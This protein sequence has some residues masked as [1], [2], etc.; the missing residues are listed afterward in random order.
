ML[1]NGGRW[2]MMPLCS[3]NYANPNSAVK[4]CVSVWE[5]QES[6]VLM[7]KNFTKVFV[8]QLCLHLKGRFQKMTQRK[9]RPARISLSVCGACLSGCEAFLGG[10]D[11]MWRDPLWQ[12]H[13]S[14]QTCQP[15]QEDS[16]S[17]PL[18]HPRK[19]WVAPFHTAGVENADGYLSVYPIRSDDPP[20]RGHIS[21]PGDRNPQDHMYD[22][23]F[24][25]R[26]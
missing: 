4:T 18:S 6:S 9:S 23:F 15:A 11:V 8:L 22:N 5:M 13:E 25:R 2:I 16:F 26:S 10:L 14:L 12:L 20:Q 3:L 24:S 21:Q 7:C 17:C 1:L 19:I